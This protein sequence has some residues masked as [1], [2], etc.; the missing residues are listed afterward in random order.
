MS[1]GS[2][3]SRVSFAS[4]RG[5]GGW[6]GRTSNASYAKRK[7][8]K[9]ISK[10]R[11]GAKVSNKFKKKV[12]ASLDDHLTGK[13]LKVHYNTF[14]APGSFAQQSPNYGNLFT[15]IRLMEAAGVLFNKDVPVEFPVQADI[16]W[17]N[18][19]IRKDFILNSWA[20]FEVKNMSQRT[21]TI[22]MYNCAPRTKAAT[23]DAFNTWANGVITA[24]GGMTNPLNNGTTTLFNDPR[25]DPSFNHMWKAEVTKIVLEPGQ[26]HLFTVQGPSQMAV[27]WTKYIDRVAAVQTIRPIGLFSRSVFFTYY[28]DLVVTS[29]GQCGRIGSTGV[30]T[31]GLAVEYKEMFKMQCPISAGFTY[32]AVVV[33]GATQQLDNKLPTRVIRI[34]PPVPTGTVQDVMEDN[35]ITVIDPVD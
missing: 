15:P 6:V 21:Y 26:S 23:D 2:S 5:A 17:T 12:R 25:Q 9:S 31:G 13:Y 33:P 24:F 3:A 29:G 16:N 22:T 8:V 14:P 10:K 35:P 4:S 27:D 1:L 18:T 34:F 7:R 28:E 30:G 32:P 19:Y 11:K 20:S